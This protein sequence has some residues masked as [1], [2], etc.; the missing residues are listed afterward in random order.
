VW[1]VVALA[2]LAVAAGVVVSSRRRPS[3]S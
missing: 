3:A 1:L 2:V